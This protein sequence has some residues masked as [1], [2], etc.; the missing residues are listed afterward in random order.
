M[1]AI[2][3]TPFLAPLSAEIAAEKPVATNPAT[4]ITASRIAWMVDWKNANTRPRVSSSTSQPTI[5]KPIGYAVPEMTPIR[6]TKIVTTARFG[7]S[8]IMRQRHRR[9]GQRDAEQPSPGEVA[10]RPL[11][12]PM[13]IA[14]PIRII[15]K[16]RLNPADPPCS[17]YW[18]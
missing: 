6:N 2:V 7:T 15:A 16:T 9:R 10:E 1:C 3:T 12:N 4:A 8:A 11:P 17:V 18:M 5:V 14:R 13:P